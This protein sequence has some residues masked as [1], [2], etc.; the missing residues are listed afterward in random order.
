[1]SK[2]TKIDASDPRSEADFTMPREVSSAIVSPAPIAP[3]KNGAELV[4][5]SVAPYPRP[6]PQPHGI[7]ALHG[8]R[9]R[10]PQIICVGLVCSAALAGSAWTIYQ[11]KFRAY[12][13]LRIHSEAPHLAFEVKESEQSAQFE[14]YKR[15]QRELV[16]GD[17]VLLA[18]PYG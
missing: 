1:M 5:S 2:N 14:V 15:T 16:L 12:A 7:P 11:P 17:E 8:L 9:R 3:G 6:A 18:A 10:W 13:S 4:V